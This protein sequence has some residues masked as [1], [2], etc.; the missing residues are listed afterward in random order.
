MGF[1]GCTVGGGQQ[2]REDRDAQRGESFAVQR[3]RE[4]DAEHQVFDHVQPFVPHQ[5]A[6]GGQW[7]GVRRQV[8][9]HR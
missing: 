6:D 7:I 8:E 9:D 3:S 2:D 5:L 4:Q 1:V